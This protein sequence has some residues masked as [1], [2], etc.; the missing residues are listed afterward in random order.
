MHLHGAA[1]LGVA[2]ATL[3]SA[4]PFTLPTGFHRFAVR[5][6]NITWGPCETGNSTNR[7]CGRFEVPLDYHNA[8]AGKASLAVARYLATK[9][10]KLG[11]L[12]LNPGGPGGSG[13]DLILGAAAEL[14]ASYGDGQYDL[15]SWDPRGV[16]LTHPRADCFA[17]GIE[18]S[19]FWE[20]TIP[21]G[22]LEAKGN[23]TDKADLDAF[24]AQVPEVDKLLVE[25]GQ[26]CLQ[27][28][29]DTFQYVGTAAA[30]RDMVALHDYLEGPDKPV[31][32]WV[33]PDRVGRVAIDGVVDPVYWANNPP[34]EFWGISTESADEALTGFVQAC[35]A[36]GPG[37][38]A[39][40]S[41]NSTADSLRAE[42]RELI[43]LA[44][45][46]KKAVG[47][48]AQFG[49]AAIRN[50]LFGGMYSP[51]EWPH[52]ASQILNISQFLMNDTGPN[53]NSPDTKRS[54]DLP[55]LRRHPIFPVTRRQN[56]SNNSDPAPDYA[57]QA[58]T[59]ADAADPGNVT[60]K[61]VFD[62]MVKV[63]REV[64]PMF[65][66]YAGPWNTQLSN[67][68]LV[69][70]NEADPIT[71]FRSAKSVTDALGNSAILIEQDDYGHASVAMHS[72][73]TFAALQ[74]YF[75]NNTLPTANKFCGTNQVLFPG[76]GITKSSLAA[77]NSGNLAA[78][79][80]SSGSTNL[81]SELDQARKR[82][83]QL[84]IVSI[85][86][87]S[88]AGLLLLSL[89]TSCLLGRKRRKTSAC[90]HAVHFPHDAHDEQGHPE[91][92][93]SRP[94]PPS[95]STGNV[96]HDQARRH[97]QS[98]RMR[99]SHTIK[100]YLAAC[101]LIDETYSATPH[102]PNAPPVELEQTLLA[103]NEEL[104][105][106][107]LNEAGLQKSQNILR[108]IQNRSKM[109]APIYSL[110]SEILARIFSEA[111][112]YCTREIELE[113]VF[114]ILSPV[115]IA[116]VCRQWRK[117]AVNQRS[118]WTHIDL[119]ASSRDYDYGYYTPETWIRRSQ[120]APLYI[121]I[122]KH[123]SFYEIDWDEDDG[124]SD[125]DERH[126]T[127]TVR[128]ILK[129]LSPL[130]P[131]VCSLNLD[132]PWPL[133]YVFNVLLSCWLSHGTIGRAK[134]LQVQ[135]SAEYSALNIDLPEDCHIFLE[136]LEVLSLYNV[137][138]HWPRLTLSNL[139]DLQFKLGSIDFGMTQ[140]ELAAI[141]ASCPKLQ[142]FAIDYITIE[143][144]YEQEINPIILNELSVLDI[145]G[146]NSIG[147]ANGVLA[148]IIPGSNTLSI[149]LPL[150]EC[151]LPSEH[152]IKDE[153]NS[154]LNRYNVRTLHLY[155]SPGMPSFATYLGPLPRVQT[156][157]FHH[158]YL[159]DNVKVYKRTSTNP[160]IYI[161][162]HP[163]NPKI[164]LWPQLQNLYLHACFLEKI[165]LHDLVLPHS[166]RTLF[167]WDC[168]EL[169][170]SHGRV[171]I[172]SPVAQEYVRFLSQVV[173]KVL[174]FQDG[175][176][177]WPS[178]SRPI[179]FVEEI[180]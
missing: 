84:F 119:M 103:V 78:S 60:T 33:F 49:S 143:R 75:L 116:S 137:L 41:Q 152:R 58:V 42:I 109:I 11:T 179:D 87:A 142:Y 38:C 153:I 24:Y 79:G 111:A 27:Y 118:L 14:I 13:V 57:L 6:K 135:S 74:N 65:E 127:Q 21:H 70:G 7:Q 51:K 133:E 31:N 123:L 149:G 69:I 61:M 167:M 76:P 178:L 59:C 113:T 25:L 15:V 16:G 147:M 136:S 10:P 52:L 161:N 122:R 17:T 105:A 163:V 40:A 131:Q 124:S 168:C 86:L 56:P 35:A 121:H 55:M 114:P 101:Q 175:C 132:F 128:K 97:L 2:L 107:S 140:V 155:G 36:A 43:D 67:P 89:I 64:S 44:Y 3:V 92:T 174:Y 150:F 139:V 68:I 104:S 157:V 66:R 54:P 120:G 34:H 28:S 39:I 22:G 106:F 48:S 117:V 166:V 73:C 20:G 85:A 53:N 4:N 102:S 45:D 171:R 138:P 100:D 159:S 90:G 148:I 29:P 1:A 88:A 144:T 5:S 63:T 18:E 180:D 129:F 154:F 125:N 95:L 156:L 130:M 62:E 93:V 82:A 160:E 32:Y 126:P 23:F 83:N 164:L 146:S 26:K 98:V 19:T 9:Q 77:L 173:P 162:F 151:F 47:P 110:P 8:T 115:A 108:D 177:T 30:V 37:N 50:G 91:S 81:E 12:F 94:G 170:R 80:S 172:E 141:L 96:T 158:C 112:C 169:P 71:P 134:S 99:L 176:S 165:H 145:G 72:D 46:Y